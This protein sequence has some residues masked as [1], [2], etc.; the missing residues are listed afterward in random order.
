MSKKSIS[1]DHFQSSFQSPLGLIYIVAS[2][3]GLVSLNWTKQ[4]GIQFL[5]SN[6]ANKYY[7]ALKF[8]FTKTTSEIEAYFKCK[9][10]EFSIPLDLKGTQFQI[11]VWNQLSKIQ[12]GKTY[13]YKDI[14][15][16]IKKPKAFR[17]VGNAIGKNPICIIIPCHRVISSNGNLGGFSAGLDKK[18]YL[19]KI[20]K[21]GVI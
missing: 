11:T 2:P 7:N 21:L 16:K 13:S 10:V 17:A 8:I 14:A 19:L 12:F 3:R 20:E 1:C 15:I 18:K 9:K 6:Q 5:E 4:S